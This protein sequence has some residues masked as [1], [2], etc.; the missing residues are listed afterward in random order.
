MSGGAIASHTEISL[1][2]SRKELAESKALEAPE[3][4]ELFNSKFAGL[5]ISLEQLFAECQEHY[6]QKS[7]WA[8]R[9]KFLKWVKEERIENYKASG[10]VVYSNET[11]QQRDARLIEANRQDRI[12]RNHYYGPTKVEKQVMDFLGIAV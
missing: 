2:K 4:K 10:D 3:I 6:E 7:L 5:N 1:K 12:R 9:D 11:S 8:T